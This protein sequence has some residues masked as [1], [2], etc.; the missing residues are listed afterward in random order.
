MAAPETWLS[1]RTAGLYI[2]IPFCQS[3]CAYC[4]F[5]SFA[6]LETLYDPYL[7]A[8]HLELAARA[9]DWSDTRFDSLYLGGG[10]PSLLPPDRIAELLAACRRLLPLDHDSEITLE[11]NPGTI[12]QGALAAYRSA[13]INRLSLGVQSLETEHLAMLGRI[14]TVD[15]AL[16][17]VAQARAAGF[18]NLSLDLMCGLP[19]QTLA[20]WRSTLARA[21]ALRP[22]HLSLYALTVEEQTPLAASIR[23][24]RLPAPDDDLAADMY[25]LAQELAQ[26][27][28]LE[29]YELSNWAR[30]GGGA[31]QS[32]H[33]LHYWHNERYLGLGA[34]ATSYDGSQRATNVAPPAAYIAAMQAGASAVTEEE[35]TP[36]PRR[37]EE[38]LMLGLRL[39]EGIGWAAFAERFGRPLEVLYGREIGEWVEQGLLVA[40]DQGIRLTPRGRLLANRVCA[41]FLSAL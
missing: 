25:E 2:H 1:A 41:S 37:I 39:A 40:D 9:D 10:T 3:K 15:E 29:Q 24:G 23:A 16:T 13:G 22:E 30:G 18:A 19:R 27:A 14:H 11:A 8:L 38:S 31:Y 12:D 35:Q 20:Q 17:A 7:Q 6:G 5:S 28:G 33:N 34:G 21:L 4:D 26:Q 32:R 36:E